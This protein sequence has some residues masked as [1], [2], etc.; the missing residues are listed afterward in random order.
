MSERT[1][2]DTAIR[3]FVDDIER[4][5]RDAALS[6][7]VDAIGDPSGTT[8]PA[9]PSPAPEATVAARLEAARLSAKERAVLELRLAGGSIATIA[10]THEVE[11]STVRTQLRRLRKK[12]A[13]VG[14]KIAH[15]AAFSLVATKPSRAARK[16]SRGSRARR[17]HGTAASARKVAAT[18]AEAP[19]AP[20]PHPTSAVVEI[21]ALG[22]LADARD[23]S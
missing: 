20:P 18:T 9:R 4:L 23:S 7:V 1:P 17:Q 11:P 6:A 3:R 8:E 15:R 19:P 22:A 13:R 10:A 21:E 2:I 16:A 14:L 12:L 5:L